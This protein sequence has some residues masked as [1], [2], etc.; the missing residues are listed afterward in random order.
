[1][2]LFPRNVLSAVL[3]V[4]AASSFATAA[5]W[6]PA[7][8]KLMTAWA[9]KVD[10]NDPLPEYPRPQMVRDTEWTN[11]NGLWDYTI[12]HRDAA[13][14]EKYD[15]K[16]LVPFCV[17]S[18]LSGVMKP[19]TDK[20]WLWYRRSFTAPKFMDGKRLL[21]H[22]GAVDWESTVSLNGKEVGTHRGGYD[23]F[24]FDITDALKAGEN[25][26]VVRVADS[27]GRGGEPHGKQSFAAIQ[28]PGGIFYTPCSGIWQTVWLEVVPEVGV[29]SLMFTPDVDL[30]VVRIKVNLRGK[31]DDSYSVSGGIFPPRLQNTKGN[32]AK[33]GKEFEVQVPN[34]RLWSPDDPFL[35][36]VYVPLYRDDKLV[37]TVTTYFAMRKI[38]LGKDE[39]GVTRL[40]LNNK[41]VFQSGPLDQGFWPDGIYTAPTDEALKSDVEAMKK[42]GF[43]MV[44]K[45]VKVEPDRWY[46]WCDKLG[47]LVWQ[48]MPSGGA[49]TG[50]RRRGGQDGTPA[51]AEKAKQ[52]EEELKAMIE[53]HRNHPSIIMWV[54]FNEGWG[55]YDTVRL[56]KWV[57]GL[58][59]SR[60][61]NDASGWTDRQAG[62]VIDMHK[63]PGPGS[64]DP[65]SARAAVLGEF[66]G[67]GLPVDG[68][69][70]V[71]KNWGYRGMADQRELNLKYLE[72]WKG[73]AKLCEE[74]GLSAAV[75]T[76]LTDVETECNGLMTYDRAVTKVDAAQ[77]AA[78][79]A[80]GQFPV[81]QTPIGGLTNTKTASKP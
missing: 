44:R 17:E 19:L 28:N 43:N 47:L 2:S 36:R 63:Y 71:S 22:F 39:K 12:T 7:P 69:R 50:S 64:P 56:T 72:L 49:G 13:K 75:Y 62:D 11:L 46:Y 68:H 80:H 55:Q 9:A 45:H 40:M 42:L 59:P 25:E 30:G 61:V 34:A 54:V 48:D 26:L 6:K 81:D 76:Q 33:A 57:K 37:D 51:S 3:A 38:S 41:P 8:G 10:P 70:W 65:E 24:T 20:Q 52:F 79:L 4:F 32:L 66:G 35:Y 53:T 29:E 27:T 16:I 14:P 15:G 67:L 73:V 60:L 77:S 31:V 58:D 78:S 74:K 23:P 5:D 18:A 21:L 1:M